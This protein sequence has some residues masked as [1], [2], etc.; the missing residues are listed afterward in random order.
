MGSEPIAPLHILQICLKDL[1]PCLFMPPPPPGPGDFC[2]V[3]TTLASRAG[4]S[5][6]Q[7]R[8]SAFID[9]A[10]LRLLIQLQFVQGLAPQRLLEFA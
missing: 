6:C 8:L 3:R 2:G 4:T 7:Q 10:L 9:R 5:L 1:H